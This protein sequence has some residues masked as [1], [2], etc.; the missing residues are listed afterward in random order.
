MVLNKLISKIPDLP[1]YLEAIIIILCSIT[2]TFIGL[3]L[4]GIALPLLQVI[5]I[6]PFSSKMYGIGDYGEHL[7]LYYYGV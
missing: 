1:L 3:I 4:G 7:A 5:V 6:V 2:A